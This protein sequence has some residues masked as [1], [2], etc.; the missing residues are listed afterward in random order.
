VRAPVG[1][2]SALERLAARA[3]RLSDSSLDFVVL[4]FGAWTVVY[5]AS[6]VL[7]IGSVG[8]A[9]AALA[10]AVPCAWLAFRRPVAPLDASEPSVEPAWPRRR[11]TV[12]MA[13]Y[14]LAVGASAAVFAFTSAPWAA[15]WILLLGAA[16]G[17]MLL[18]F[19]RATG[20]FELDRSG[21]EGAPPLVWPG[22][23][24]AL[25]WA[26]G[27]AVLSLYLVRPD[28]DDT[29]YVRLTTW[30]ADRGEFPLR[31]ILFS[32]QVFEAVFYP[33]L[34]SFEALVGTAGRIGGVSGASA[35]YYLVPPLA[36]ALA[37]LAL[38]RLLR[39]WRV[40]L[41]GLG[42]STALVFLL[43]AAQEHR[44]LGNLFIGRIW[45]GKVVF[46]AVLVPLLFVLL[47]EYVERPTRRQLVLVA[48]AG[49]AGVGLTSTGSFLVPVLAAGGLAP[50][51]LRSWQK[52]AVGFAAVAAY[53]LG[54]LVVSAAV[55]GRRAGGDLA[56]DVVANDIAR[57]VLGDGLFAFIALCAALVAPLLIRSLR[58]ALMGAGTL[59]LVVLLF[60]PPVPSLIWEISGIG[61]VLWRVAWVVPFA[62]L[63][64]VVATAVPATVRPRA[65][66]AVPA[67]L[68]CAVLVAWGSP[69]WSDTTVAGEPAWKRFE[70]QIAEARRIL[71]HAKPGDV[72]LAPAQVSQ[73]ILVMSSDVT[74]VSP[75]PFYVLALDD[76]PGAHAD[77]RLL[78]AAAIEPEIGGDI[79]GWLDQPPSA[80]EVAE[81]LE[82]VGVDIA[83]AN[84]HSPGRR[85]LEEAG[86]ESAFRAK[87]LDCFV[88]P[89]QA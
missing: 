43:M 48:A 1:A 44:T 11:L 86:Y 13:G 63:V 24:V 28:S 2:A 17:G 79:E 33:P 53:P 8:A 62:A 50:F 65:L 81:A 59:L 21:D 4:A 5:H 51:A 19:L 22:A 49:A 14:G 36:S 27:L 64:G 69:V 61:R 18:A 54:A 77:K 58:G 89:E 74:T 42:L 35:T 34:S 57:F 60:A 70:T 29:Q 6:L 23:L 56:S 71:A 20:R 9:I 80:A 15:V 38:W 47:H 55:G 88:P 72:I 41:V 73:T 52:A 46:L 66:R 76:V 83:C 30:I 7:D 25:A 45:Q 67:L 82:G 75:R 39:T 10:A 3:V 16:G 87:R 32:D 68:L 26:V 84:R 31:D 78:L 40:R 37:V 12:I 85:T